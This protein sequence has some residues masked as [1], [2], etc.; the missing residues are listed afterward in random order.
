ML[1]CSF[2]TFEI[3]M[4]VQRSRSIQTHTN[5]SINTTRFESFL[6]S[7]I[8]PTSITQLQGELYITTHY[9]TVK[10]AVNGLSYSPHNRRI[11][12]WPYLNCCPATVG[13]NFDCKLWGEQVHLAVYFCW[14]R[15]RSIINTEVCT[16]FHQSSDLQFHPADEG[17][18]LG[19]YNHI[20]AKKRYLE[21]YE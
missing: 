18:S 8:H 5:V 1:S 16:H 21:C 2:I 4:D 13:L 7:V 20:R 6:C 14:R 11:T 10:W 9:V 15:T 19:Q 12:Q 3:Q 17:E